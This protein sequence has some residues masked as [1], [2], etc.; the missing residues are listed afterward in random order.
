MASCCCFDRRTKNALPEFDVAA[1]ITASVPALTIGIGASPSCDGQVL[2]TE[3]VIGLFTE[4]TPKFVKKY[5]E[6]GEEVGRAASA[7]SAEV[8]SRAFPA[9]EHCYRKK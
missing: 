6:V 2:V 4:F 1:E 8:K 7:F 9:P 3:D 5:A